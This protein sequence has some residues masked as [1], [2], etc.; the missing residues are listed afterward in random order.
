MFVLLY[1]FT[2][3]FFVMVAH[4]EYVRYQH[5]FWDCSA[6]HDADSELLNRDVCTSYEDRLLFKN[7]V[8]CAGAERRLL[9]TVWR[10]A[11]T[12]W[13]N[14]CQFYSKWWAL[15]VGGPLVVILLYLWN[16]RR[17]KMSVAHLFIESFGQVKDKKKKK[18]Y[19]KALEY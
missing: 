8:D 7:K 19:K 16:D 2:G 3:L 11:V 4:N 13:I 15:G 18:K 17:T 6:Q 1:F 12:K 5:A 10:C 14:E 9:A